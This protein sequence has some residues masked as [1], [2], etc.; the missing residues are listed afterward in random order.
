VRQP[1]DEEIDLLGRYLRQRQDRPVEACRQIV[2]A[3]LAS[4]EFRFN[5]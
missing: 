3:L 5:Y 4:T 2:W 1:T